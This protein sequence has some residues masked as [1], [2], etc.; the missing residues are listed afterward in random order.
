MD[1]ISDRFAASDLDESGDPKYYG[2]L[3]A[4]GNWYIMESSDSA[5]TFRYCYGESGY[6]AAW[7]G[8]AGLTYGLFSVIF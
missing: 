3:A 6:S 4:N 7:T 5:G 1:P 8:R 2:F